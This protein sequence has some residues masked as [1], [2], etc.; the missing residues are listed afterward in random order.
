[1]PQQAAQQ[2]RAAA[3]KH[4]TATPAARGVRSS[5]N[6]GAKRRSASSFPPSPPTT[7]SPT[8]R[9]LFCNTCT[10]TRGPHSKLPVY[11]PCSMRLFCTSGSQVARVRSVFVRRVSL[12]F[13]HGL[14]PSQHE[15]AAPPSQHERREAGCSPD[16]GVARLEEGRSPD[17][18]ARKGRRR[19]P[20]S[21]SPPARPTH[22]PAAGE[23]HS[24][25]QAIAPPA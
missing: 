5:P 11:P 22:A 12:R 7:H 15:A 14:Q 21:D 16:Q 6:V 10:Q 20:A 25:R 1:M 8:L 19:W 2:R 13:R 3:A 17:Q 24:R 9:S 23:S 18:V 4:A